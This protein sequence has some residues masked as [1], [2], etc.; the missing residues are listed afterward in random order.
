MKIRTGDTV[1]VLTGKDKGKEGKVIQAF[2]KLAMVVVEGLNVAT[3]H[4]KKRGT[5]AGQRLTYSAPIKL[6]NVALVAGKGTGRVG[7]T[8]KMVDG[9]MQRTRV[10]RKGKTVTEIA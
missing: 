1:K 7:Y 5:T 10:V 3:K 6:Q 9:K 2:P 4:V 8:L